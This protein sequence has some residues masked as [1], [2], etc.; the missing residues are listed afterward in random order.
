MI[1]GTLSNEDKRH[2]NN[3]YDSVY[4]YTGSRP[5]FTGSKWQE[6]QNL[7]NSI[8]E[9]GCKQIFFLSKFSLK[10][11]YSFVLWFSG[12]FLLSHLHDLL[13]DK[14]L[15]LFY[16]EFKTPKIQIFLMKT[17]GGIPLMTWTTGSAKQSVQV[18]KSSPFNSYWS[19]PNSREFY[20]T[21]ESWLE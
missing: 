18:H 20:L 14:E 7:R 5:W 9:R 16:K 1:I 21:S 12:T 17:V 15:L 11:N 19:P 2:D 8:G 13:N 10:L 6:N 3:K 4:W